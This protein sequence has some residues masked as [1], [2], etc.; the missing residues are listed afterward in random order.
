LTHGGGEAGDVVIEQPNQYFELSL[1][2]GKEDGEGKKVEGG[3]IK[4]EG[5]KVVDEV[6]KE[7]VE[8]NDVAGVEVVEEKMDSSE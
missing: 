5:V 4:M 7:D 2:F 3:D 6:K 8:M 1:K